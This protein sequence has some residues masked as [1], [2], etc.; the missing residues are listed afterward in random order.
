MLDTIYSNAEAKLEE[1]ISYL[2]SDL[3]KLHV[4][5]ATPSLIEDVKVKAYDTEMTVKELGAISA[6]QPNLLVVSCW[7]ETV[8]DAIGKSLQQQSVGLNPVIDGKVLKV[9]IPVL[10]DERR[11]AMVKEVGELTEKTRVEVRQIR[12]DKM[13]SVDDLKEEKKI[14]EDEH[15]AAKEDIQALINETNEKIE[16]IKKEKIASLES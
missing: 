15:A 12:Q 1:R 2:Q 7:D 3:A 4:G 13:K 14:S 11:A 8:V 6:P 16:E 5:H 9:P 10:S